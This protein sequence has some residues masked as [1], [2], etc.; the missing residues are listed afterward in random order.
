MELKPSH[1]PKRTST[2]AVARRE[3]EH[4]FLKTITR[5]YRGGF[6]GV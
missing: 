3:R 4:D 5:Q 2:A 1:H 6:N